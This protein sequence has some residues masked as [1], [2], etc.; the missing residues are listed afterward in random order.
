MFLEEF[1]EIDLPESD[2]LFLL[3]S[4]I[5]LLKRR[6]SRINCRASTNF[7][8]MKFHNQ[9]PDKEATTFTENMSAK[10]GVQPSSNH[11]LASL[12][13]T[14]IRKLEKS[15]GSRFMIMLTRHMS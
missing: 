3:K 9:V 5:H 12:S 1:N 4:S 6:L 11:R 7:N 2:E 15:K 8:F 10:Y 14:S 13:T